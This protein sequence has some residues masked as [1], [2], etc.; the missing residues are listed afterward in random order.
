MLPL[1]IVGLTRK[2]TPLPGVASDHPQLEIMKSHY[3]I[4]M[5]SS[6]NTTRGIN[7]IKK[8]PSLPYTSLYVC[9]KLHN[10][11]THFTVNTIQN[12]DRWILGVGATIMKLTPP[13]LENLNL[14]PCNFVGVSGLKLRMWPFSKKAQHASLPPKNHPQNP[15]FFHFFWGFPC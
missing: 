14:L 4:L 8:T 2:V 13:L 15:M 10:I 3:L 11:D 12:W 1:W 6:G 5:I 9:Y 7:G